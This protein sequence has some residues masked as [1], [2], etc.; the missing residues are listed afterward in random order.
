MRGERGSE[1]GKIKVEEEE[2]GETNVRKGSLF[3][4]QTTHLFYH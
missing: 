2:G 1:G 4:S 3:Y